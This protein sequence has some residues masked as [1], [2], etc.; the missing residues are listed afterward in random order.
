LKREEGGIR[1]KKE[2]SFLF[3]FLEGYRKNFSVLSKKTQRRQGFQ[4]RALKDWSETFLSCLL[5]IEKHKKKEEADPQKK[6]DAG[7]E[8][9]RGKGRGARIFIVW[10]RPGRQN[11][12]K[13]QSKN[14]SFQAHCPALG[15]E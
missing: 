10:H 1:V 2:E 13:W 15:F 14:F 6:K 3:F 4:T 9:R 5:Q 8:E 7:V 12:M 11:P